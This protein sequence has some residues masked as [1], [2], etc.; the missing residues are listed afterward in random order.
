MPAYNPTTKLQKELINSVAGILLSC[1]QTNDF[2][3]P[4]HVTDINEELNKFKYD[5]M[6]DEYIDRLSN[7]VNEILNQIR[8]ADRNINLSVHD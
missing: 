1:R 4:T 3:S 7:L 2:S 5:G 6:N 8:N